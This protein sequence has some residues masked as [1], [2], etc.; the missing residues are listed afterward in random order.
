[1]Y[2]I[3]EA[4]AS[5]FLLARQFFQMQISVHMAS[6]V[7]FST[8]GYHYLVS[9]QLITY[10]VT[11]KNGKIWKPQQKLKKSKKKNLLTEN[12]PLQLAF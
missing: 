11:Q 4:T 1:M 10:R 7:M 3:S 2:N 12:E 8:A 5:L 6:N 9:T